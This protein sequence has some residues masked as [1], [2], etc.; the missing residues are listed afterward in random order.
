MHETNV[1]DVKHAQ[2]NVFTK[3]IQK[4]P[5]RHMKKHTECAR[6]SPRPYLGE[7]HA[8]MEIENM[9]VSS[10]YPTK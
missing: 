2:K 4:L 3:T 6:K 1:I 7:L 10:T 9:N 5:A 8:G